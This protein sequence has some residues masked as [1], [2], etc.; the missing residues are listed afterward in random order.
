MDWI[1]EKLGKATVGIAGLGGLGSTVAA[2]M[3]RTGVGR[4]VVVDFDV[5]EESNLNRQQY[6]AD[7]IGKAKVE[8][9]RRTCG[10]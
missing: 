10:V 5:V 6:F 9:P 4:L 8:A 2:A 7:Q 1:Y 3:T